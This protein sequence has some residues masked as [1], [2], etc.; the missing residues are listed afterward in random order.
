MFACERQAGMDDST[1]EAG[2]AA[3]GDAGEASRSRRRLARVSTRRSLTG[4][5]VGHL[6]GRLAGR[7][8]ETLCALLLVVMAVNLVTV[9]SQKSITTDEIVLIPAAYAYVQSGDTQ[10]VHEHPPL[11]KLLA[12]LPL[13][14]FA[15][16]LKMLPA[17]GGAPPRTIAQMAT[18]VGRL[19]EDNH[20]A[21]GRVSFIA[22]LPLIALTLAL[23]VLVFVFAREL[24]GARAALLAVALFSI[25]PTVLAHGRVVQTDIAAAFGYLLLCRAV[26]RYALLAPTWRRAVWIGAAAALAILAKFSM[27]LVAPVVAA[28]FAVLLWRAQREARGR[29]LTVAAHAALVALTV[30]CLVNAAYLFNHSPL[31]DTDAQWIAST[32]PANPNLMLNAARTL[33]RVLPLDFVLGIFWQIAHNE[34]GHPA[35]L[36]GM[37]SDT[38]WWYYYP[39]A[40]ALKTT[41]PFLLLSLASVAWG[42]YRAVR[43][44]ERPFL[45]AIVPFAVYTGFVLL[46]RIDIGV[47][48]YLPAYMLLFITGGALLDQLLKEHR[49]AGR[50]IALALLA[51]A[52]VEAV[53]AYPDHMPY[54]N[55]LAA[56]QPH[57]HYL[58]D[59]NV[60][61]GDD[62]R[63]LAG[64]LRA[65]GETRVRAAALAADHMLPCYG[66]ENL[67]LIRPSAVE[68]PPTRYVAIGAS[69]LNGSTV[70]PGMSVRG[71]Q[72][73]EA[74]RV[75]YFD[76]Y[77]HRAPEAVFG[78]SIY[79][80]R[81]PE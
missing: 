53:R 75:N 60:E 19:W 61:W 25:E 81:E 22:R 58:S 14:L 40:F 76:A 7:L 16:P 28:V 38:G 55:Q 73:T 47:R 39:V 10:L 8:N 49:R 34:R 13:R 78:D 18:R 36:L 33:S 5:P 66:I 64:Y 23:G 72:L 17:E 57:W 41:L 31:L 37:Y 35:S 48:Y 70:P 2:D 20:A 15:P 54:M 65:R 77:R 42:A 79:L 51:W 56:G 74:E 24:F 45:V 9:I 46:S 3:A 68:L 32:F 52:C 26:Y 59:S 1:N 30:L 71:R 63:A 44:R 67:N 21:V 62:V 12:G 29:V 4:R 11:V 69:F 27:L 80:F 43:R 6:V 50:I